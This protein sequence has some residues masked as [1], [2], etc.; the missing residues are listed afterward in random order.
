MLKVAGSVITGTLTYK[1]TWDAST[2]DPALASGVGTLNNYYVVSVAGNTNLDGQ[3]N[4]GVGDW[5][6]FNGTVW[7]KIDGGDTGNF[8]TI[9]VSVLATLAN[10]NITS[11][12]FNTATFATS[13][14]PLVP[15]GYVSISVGGV[16]KK[17]PYYGV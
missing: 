17:I 4:W 15:E 3:A 7:Q 1:G 8:T 6:I 13:S 5:A 12:T 2:N 14:L 10:V 16:A 11:T 9:D